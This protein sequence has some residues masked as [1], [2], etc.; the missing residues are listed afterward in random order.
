MFLVWAR[1]ISRYK[2]EDKCWKEKLRRKREHVMD[3]S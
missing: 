2:L 3:L 1:W